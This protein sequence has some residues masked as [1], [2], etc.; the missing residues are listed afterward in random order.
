MCPREQAQHFLARC[1][2]CL[3]RESPTRCVCPDRDLGYR[4]VDRFA[5][6]Y[7]VSLGVPLG[8]AWAGVQEQLSV[9]CGNRTAVCP[10][11]DE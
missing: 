4:S 11:V 1:E 8:G 2:G 7:Y 6:A 9:P 5:V 10:N 3:H